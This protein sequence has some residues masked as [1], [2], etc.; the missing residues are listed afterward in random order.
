MVFNT[1]AALLD[2]I[3]LASVS[4]D[5]NGT[6]GYKITQDVRSILDISE[7][8]LYPVLRRLQKDHFLETYDQAFNGRNR[9][10]Y[11]I[12]DDGRTK[13]SEYTD[14]WKDYTAKINQLFLEEDTIYE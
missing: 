8:T 9:R 11:R 10:Y 4:K 6:Y 7:S 12:T 5:T 2:A 1:G 14:A 13:L 3:V